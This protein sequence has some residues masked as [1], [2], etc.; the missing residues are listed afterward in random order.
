VSELPETENPR[1]DRAWVALGVLAVLVAVVTLELLPISIAAFL[2]AG[3]LVATR[4][5]TAA[6]ARRSIEWPIL[7]VIAASLGIGL[8]MEKTGVAAATARALTAGIGEIGPLGA[9]AI[10]YFATVV[11][12]EAISNNAAA[13]L[14]FPISL[15]TATQLGVDNRGFIMAVTIA[16]SC[17]FATPIGYQTHL[18]VYGPGGYR[19]SDFVRVGLPL[20]ILCGIVAVAVIPFVFPF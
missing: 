17:G 1:Y 2:A 6:Q 13:A 16:A 18:I 14:M 4:C 7:I 3:A 20:D 5:I 11:L 19:F 8:A 9:L 15:A 10:V 12:T